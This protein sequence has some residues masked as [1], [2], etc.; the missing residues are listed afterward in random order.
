[1]YTVCDTINPTKEKDMKVYRKEKHYLVDAD[2]S[3]DTPQIEIKEKGSGLAVIKDGGFFCLLVEHNDSYYDLGIVGTDNERATLR[4][5]C[6][7]Y[8]SVLKERQDLCDAIIKHI[9]KNLE[10]LDMIPNFFYLNI[11][12]FA[13]RLQTA[14]KLR[15]YDDYAKGSADK[16]DDFLVQA[17]QDLNKVSAYIEKQEKG[18]AALDL[19]TGEKKTEAVET[20][21]KEAADYDE[22]LDH[23][24]TT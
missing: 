22:I 3:F 13:E 11:P 12:N 5:L 24:S 20:D 14:V 21:D 1:M 16:I 6:A 19:L 2:A 8:W 10:L 15:L 9:A 7:G 4:K 18:K 23:N 17:E